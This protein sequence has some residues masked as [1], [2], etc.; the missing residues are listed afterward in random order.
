MFVVAGI[1]GNT[2]KV[3]ARALRAQGHKVRALVRRP[4][5][6]GTVDADESVVAA[7]EDPLALAAALRGAQGAYLLIPPFFGPNM[8]A[9]QQRVAQNIKTA[10]EAS[11]IERSVL[12]SSIAAE[13]PSNTGPI[14]AVHRLEQLTQEIPGVT[15]LRAAYFQENWLHMLNAAQTQGV[16]PSFLPQHA[17]PMVATQDIGETAAR[18]L[19]QPS[20]PPRVVQLAGPRDFTAQDAAAALGEVLGKP[21]NA[22]PLPVS[23]VVPGFVQVGLPEELAQLYAEMYQAAHEGRM[24]WQEDLPLVRGEHDLLSTFRAHL[25]RRA[26]A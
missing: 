24:S 13:Q 4:E 25:G 5:A 14:V 2:G 21:V 10:L 6:A 9:H 11:R 17:F 23:D 3:V 20:A 12:L 26:A 1:T 16:L 15:A 22:L 7:L 19:T 18:L 8:L